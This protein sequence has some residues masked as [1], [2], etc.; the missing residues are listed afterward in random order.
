MKPFSKLTSQQDWSIAIFEH[1]AVI[2]HD[3]NVQKSQHSLKPSGSLRLCE[4]GS[5]RML[6]SSGS[7]LSSEIH[8]QLPSIMIEAPLSQLPEGSQ[9]IKTTDRSWLLSP[10]GNIIEEKYTSYFEFQAPAPSLPS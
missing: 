7:E 5:S 3:S 6:C 2:G 4:T 8:E 10:I 1:Q 9:V